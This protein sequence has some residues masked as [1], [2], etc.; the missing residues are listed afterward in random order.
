MT[1]KVVSASNAANAGNSGDAD[2]GTASY[3][4][5]VAAI[6]PLR[7]QWLT[8][9]KCQNKKPAKRIRRVRPSALWQ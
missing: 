9:Y 6:I 2:S 7:S 4:N 8:T 5:H 3:A 1:L